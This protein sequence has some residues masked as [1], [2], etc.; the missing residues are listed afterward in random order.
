MKAGKSGDCLHKFGIATLIVFLVITLATGLM[1]SM[2]TSESVKTWYPALNK[3][4]WKPKR[5]PQD[6]DVS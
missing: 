5:I 3:P 2:V 1:G 6:G 4:A